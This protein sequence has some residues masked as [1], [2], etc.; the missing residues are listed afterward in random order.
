VWDICFCGAKTYKDSWESI[1]LPTVQVLYRSTMMVK[2]GKEL[3]VAINILELS[4]V[5][6]VFISG[7]EIRKGNL[8]I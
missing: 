5:M 2:T 4:E 7:A 3:M 8:A 1:I 6:A